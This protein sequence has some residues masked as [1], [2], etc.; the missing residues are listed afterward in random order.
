MD[1]PVAV[2]LKRIAVI[3]LADRAVR[4]CVE[5]SVKSVHHRLSAERTRSQS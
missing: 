5:I 4:L 1:D 3:G 2:D